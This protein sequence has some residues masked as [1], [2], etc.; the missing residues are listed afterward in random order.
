MD[1]VPDF[2]QNTFTILPPLV[3]P[4]SQFLNAIFG[5]PLPPFLMVQ[6]LL[7]QTVLKPI[8]LNGELCVR[9]IKVQKISSQIMLPAEFESGE[10][11]GAKRAPQLFFFLSLP[12]SKTA[13]GVL[14]FHCGRLETGWAGNSITPL[15]NPLPARFLAERGDQKASSSSI[16]AGYCGGQRPLLRAVEEREGERR[17][18][19]IP[20]PAPRA[21]ASWRLCVDAVSAFLVFL[22]VNIARAEAPPRVLRVPRAQAI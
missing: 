13:G 14:G 12:A 5:K 20:L 10:T 8:Q 6:I 11:P 16:T 19:L 15:P 7:R 21:F 4:K 1:R 9:T 17:R 22:V 2:Q 3:V 18:L